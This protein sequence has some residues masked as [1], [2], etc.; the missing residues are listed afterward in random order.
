MFNFFSKAQVTGDFGEKMSALY[1]IL[2]FSEEKS[3]CTDQ[4]LY[5]IAESV[6]FLFSK[7]QYETKIRNGWKTKAVMKCFMIHET[8]RQTG[9]KLCVTLKNT[10]CK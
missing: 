8:K 2:F 9:R 1:V 5:K 7:L 4:I 3:A 6:I 10:N